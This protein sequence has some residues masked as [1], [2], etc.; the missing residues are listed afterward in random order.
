MI[1]V[2]CLN[3]GKVQAEHSAGSVAYCIDASGAFCGTTYESTMFNVNGGWVAE[4]PNTVSR[5]EFARLRQELEDTLVILSEE[6]VPLDVRRR[7][8]QALRRVKGI[9]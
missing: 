4:A 1:E 6:A 9:R 8:I 7:A 5:A 3:C 2:H